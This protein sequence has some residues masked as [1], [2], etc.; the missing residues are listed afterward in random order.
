MAVDEAVGL[1]FAN[2][3][4]LAATTLAEHNQK[5]TS[6]RYEA[7]MTGVNG[8]YVTRAELAAHL[9]P[10]K[11][12]IRETSGDVKQLLALYHQEKGKSQIRHWAANIAVSLMSG[13]AV[14][15]FVWWLA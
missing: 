8:N 11:E 13:G 9:E 5:H 2:P 14:T 7:R 4:L 1:P 10:M 15:I 12:D 6:R 3:S